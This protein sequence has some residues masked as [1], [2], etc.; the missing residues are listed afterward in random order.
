[1]LARKKESAPGPDGL[2]YSVY[3]CAGGIGAW[4]LLKDNE[5]LIAR[6]SP[7]DGFAASRTVFIPKS[8]GARCEKGRVCRPEVDSCSVTAAQWLSVDSGAAGVFPVNLGARRVPAGSGPS[9]SSSV[10]WTVKTPRR[11]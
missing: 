8:F 5:T 3:R 11:K 6:G 2:P 4:L 10:F 9:T 7:P 1:M